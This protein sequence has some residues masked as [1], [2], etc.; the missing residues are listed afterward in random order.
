MAEDP[1][2]KLRHDLANPL[3]ALLT[4]TQILLLNEAALDPDTVHGLR[5]IESIARHM[6]DMLVATRDDPSPTGGSTT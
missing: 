2:R 1:L 6:R 3:A 4:E 5:E